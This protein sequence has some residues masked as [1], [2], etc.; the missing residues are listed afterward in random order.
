[1]VKKK[2]IQLSNIIFSY[3]ARDLDNINRCHIDKEKE[4][5]NRD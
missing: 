5:I 4:D 1:M 2:I 3:F